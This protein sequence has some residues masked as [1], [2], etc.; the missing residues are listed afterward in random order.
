MAKFFHYVLFIFATVATMEL[1]AEAAVCTRQIGACAP[2][3]SDICASKYPNGGKGACQGDSCV[4]FYEC[5]TEKRCNVGL[6][7]VQRSAMMRVVLQNV[8]S[9]VL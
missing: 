5:G 8:L 3:C 7:L 9:K 2:S 6:G 4:C 1:S